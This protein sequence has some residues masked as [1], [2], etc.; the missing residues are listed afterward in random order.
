MAR[1]FA[2][3]QSVDRPVDQVWTELTDWEH[4]PLWMKGV[5]SA[6]A[7][8][9]PVVGT[10]VYFRARGKE[11]SS[12]ITAVSPGRSLTL[13]SVQGG[14][15]ADYTYSL[16]S[17][18]NGRTRMSLVADCDTRGVW[19]VLGPL[20]RGVIRRTD[21]GQLTALKSRIESGADR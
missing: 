17:D 8:G 6:R 5:D 3:T 18:G 14:V 9:D 20:L 21:G 16:E 7:N 19:T 1:A 11:R 12:R 13:R 2:V 15:T 10:I 4:A